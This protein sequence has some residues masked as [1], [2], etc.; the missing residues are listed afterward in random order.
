MTVRGS[1]GIIVWRLACLANGRI[2]PGLPPSWDADPAS[3]RS[4]PRRRASPSAPY[5]HAAE[6]YYFFFRNLESLDQDLQRVP[7]PFRF[8]PSV[9]SELK[10][11]FDAPTVHALERDVLRY[12]ARVQH[13]E[14][15]M[16]RAPTVER[17][18]K[19]FIRRF[20]ALIRELAQ[21]PPELRGAV[22]SFEELLRFMRSRLD[23]PKGRPI[24][25]PRALL[26]ED[27]GRTL[28][29]RGYRVTK[30]RY[31]GLAFA[32]MTVIAAV[33]PTVELSDPMPI[34]IRVCDTLR[35]EAQ[36][37]DTPPDDEVT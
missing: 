22:G 7:C 25:I 15:W 30:Y 5:R 21:S 37:P 17:V 18:R 31:G 19:R 2:P 32:L 33:D 6:S 20:D 12:Q 9:R 1:P 3:G 23:V 34:C 26:E 28:E 11:R 24:D 13:F 27:I 8:E 14:E 10:R 36:E 35:R 29:L 16:R 4:M